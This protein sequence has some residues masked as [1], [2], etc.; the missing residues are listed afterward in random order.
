MVL[1]MAPSKPVTSRVAVGP[2]R[3]DEALTADDV[4]IAIT[5]AVNNGAIPI[6][7][8]SVTRIARFTA[9]ARMFF[10]IMI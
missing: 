10:L 1:P 5:A 4:I 8:D 3:G 7:T 6:P 9:I 2:P